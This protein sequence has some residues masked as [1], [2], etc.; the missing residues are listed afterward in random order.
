MTELIVLGVIALACN[1]VHYRVNQRQ[2]ATI[3]RLTD[4]LMAKDYREY[5]TMQPRESVPET[6]KRK[7]MSWY[8]DPNIEDE[9]D[10]H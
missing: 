5:V 2:Q 3:D 7:P 1:I 10:T 8:D 4:K 6:P 9:H